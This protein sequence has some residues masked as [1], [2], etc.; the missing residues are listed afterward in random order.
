MIW[1]QRRLL[2]QVSGGFPDALKKTLSF[3]VKF[4][5]WKRINTITKIKLTDKKKRNKKYFFRTKTRDA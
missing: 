4:I 1:K 5:P 2:N 3:Q